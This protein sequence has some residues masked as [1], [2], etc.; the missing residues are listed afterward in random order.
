MKMSKAESLKKFV[1]TSL[2][3]GCMLLCV[4]ACNEDENK[5][6]YPPIISELVEVHTNNQGECSHLLTDQG[7]WLTIRNRITMTDS[8]TK[9][10]VYRCSCRYTLHPDN[11][12]EAVIYS[13]R[14]I[15]SFHPIAAHSI[16]EIKSD[17]LSLQSVWIGGKYLN[18]ALLVKSQKENHSYKVVE[19]SLKVFMQGGKTLHLRLYHDAGKDVEAYTQIVYLSVPL[20]HYLPILQKG[21]TIAIGINI[22]GKGWQTW[23]TPFI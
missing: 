7:T 14:Q 4:V 12:N 1:F 21:D 15:P 10:S 20:Y 11:P 5:Y 18:L 22:S 3:V 2:Q 8:L 9:D 17:P 13:L 19:D 16:S 23:K 6:I